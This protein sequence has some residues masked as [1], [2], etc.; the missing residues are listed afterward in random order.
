MHQVIFSKQSPT[1]LSRENAGMKIWR[2]DIFSC[3][4][5]LTSFSPGVQIYAVA[6]NRFLTLAYFRIVLKNHADHA[7]RE[8]STLEHAV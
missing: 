4:I 1:T 5:L 3:S 2:K 8:N 7:F 6:T